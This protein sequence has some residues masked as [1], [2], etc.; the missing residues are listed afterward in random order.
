M[1]AC[2][3]QTRS[4]AFLSHQYDWTTGVPDN[5]SFLLCGDPL[6]NPRRT[7]PPEGCI[8]LGNGG[9]RKGRVWGR[10]GP[11]GR[12]RKERIKDAQKMVSFCQ[13]MEEVPCRT[14]LVPLAFPCFRTFFIRGGNR[15][16]FRPTG[17]GGGSFPLYGGTFARSYSVSI[18]SGRNIAEKGLKMVGHLRWAKSRDSY[19]RIAS[20]SYPKDPSVLKIVRHSNPYYF[21]TTVVFQYPYRFPAS[22][23]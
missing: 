20:E 7:P 9:P 2:Q 21:A 22:F 4:C 17:V 13:W 14:S 5:P 23:S 3:V 19:R 10:K 18:F 8:P 12:G 1:P 6:Q 11:V 15:R 16:A